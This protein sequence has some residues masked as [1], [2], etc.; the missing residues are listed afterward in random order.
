MPLNSVCQYVKGLLNGLVI[1]LQDDPLEAWVQ[2][3]TVDNPGAPK[4]YI[5]GSTGSWKRQTMPRGPGFQEFTWPLEIFLTLT[6][7]TQVPNKDQIQNLVVDTV[8]MTLLKAVMPVMITD[9]TT[10]Q[11][12]QFWSIGESGRIDNPP[13]RTGDSMRL[14]VFTAGIAVTVK[15]V[16]QA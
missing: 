4:A 6:T 7:S 1:P 3:P 8:L 16:V 2:P 13:A 15:E 5:W 12:T 9:P 14:L 10:G 11:V